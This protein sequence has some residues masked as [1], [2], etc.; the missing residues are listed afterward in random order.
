MQA[1]ILFPITLILIS[2]GI[3]YNIANAQNTRTDSASYAIPPKEL[4]SIAQQ[5]LLEIKNKDFKKLSS[6][7]HPQKGIRFEPYFEQ[8]FVGIHFSINQFKKVYAGHQK[9]LWG[10]YDGSG[11]PIRMS[12]SNYYKKFIYSKNYAAITPTYIKTK[13]PELQLPHNFD[14]NDSDWATQYPNGIVVHYYY[15]STDPLNDMNWS[16]LGLVFENY[17]NKWY[18]V[19][20][21]RDVWQI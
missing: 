15:K 2:C 1:K 8:Q 21:L 6:K 4:I 5:T 16:A 14:G 18:L 11:N 12:F 13:S 20:I 7:I 3:K 9:Y 10:H 17:N 19:A